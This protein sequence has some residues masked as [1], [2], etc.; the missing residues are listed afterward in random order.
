[1]RIKNN[2]SGFTLIE[3]LITIALSLLLSTVGLIVYKN[4]YE[5]RVVKLVASNWAKEVR[6]LIKKNESASI[7]KE[8]SGCQGAFQGSQIQT[9]AASPE[10]TLEV[11]CSTQ[12]ADVVTYRLDDLV[13]RQEVVFQNGVK[14]EILPL[15]HGLKQAVNVGFCFK[16]L[17]KCYYQVKVD[18]NGNLEVES[19]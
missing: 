10:Y 8:V 6:L 5:H 9:T 3:A 12:N 14:L 18:K 16:T 17:D 13:S 4:Y 1:M 19:I 7:L 11:K 15:S 2:F